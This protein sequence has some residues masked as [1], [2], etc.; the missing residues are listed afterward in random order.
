MNAKKKIV[1]D[2]EGEGGRERARHKQKRKKHKSIMSYDG[3]GA[4]FYT[5]LAEIT[6]RFLQNRGKSKAS[7]WGVAENCEMFGDLVSPKRVRE[8]LNRNG[9]ENVGYR[10]NKFLDHMQ[11]LKDFE[12]RGAGG[13]DMKV[14]VSVSE[15]GAD[16]FT[17]GLKAS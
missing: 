12:E 17:F 4:E 1:S 14:K 13:E 6:M 10:T 9:K 8:E 7:N 11:R 16:V 5:W 2:E 3:K 15:V